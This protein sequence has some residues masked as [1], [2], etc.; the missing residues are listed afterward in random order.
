MRERERERERERDGCLK[1]TLNVI[2]LLVLCVSSSG[3]NGLVC[4][5]IV[6]F[7]GHIL[8]TFIMRF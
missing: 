7:P 6:V 3:C 4:S 5:V 8:P 1:I 2:G